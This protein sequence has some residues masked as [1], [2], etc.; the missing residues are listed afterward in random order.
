VLPVDPYLLYRA[1]PCN[2]GS[3]TRGRHARSLETL[4]RLAGL[5]LVRCDREASLISYLESI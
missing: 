4:A 1:V 2:H 3:L 5:R